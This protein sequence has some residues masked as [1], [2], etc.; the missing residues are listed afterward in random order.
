MN[1]KYLTLAAVNAYYQGNLG[2]HST[3]HEMEESARLLRDIAKEC[4]R[5]ADRLRFERKNRVL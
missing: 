5:L 4:Q 2:V 3:E 1:K